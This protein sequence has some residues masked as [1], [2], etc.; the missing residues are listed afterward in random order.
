MSSSRSTWFR[1]GKGFSSLLNRR[2][3]DMEVLEPRQ[4]LATDQWINPAGGSWDVASN[5][6]NGVPGVV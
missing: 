3:P 4:L 1:G 5:W 6:S 2:R